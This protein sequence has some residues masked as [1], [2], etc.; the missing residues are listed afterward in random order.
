MKVMYLGSLEGLLFG[1]LAGDSEEGFKAMTS[2]ECGVLGD[3]LL[4][5]VTATA[6]AACLWGVTVLPSVVDLPLANLAFLLASSFFLLPLMLVRRRGMFPLFGCVL[7]CC[8]LGL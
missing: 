5:G 7:D 1:F 6:A 4:A 2:L 3:V 8:F